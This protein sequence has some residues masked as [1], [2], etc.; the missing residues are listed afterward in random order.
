MKS[1][2]SLWATGDNQ[3][4]LLG[5]NQSEDQLVTTYSE[6]TKVTSV[7]TG[8]VSISGCEVTTTFAIGENG[9]ITDVYALGDNTDGALGDGNGKLLTAT[10][11]S[12]EMPFSSVPV[13][14]LLPE[15]ETYTMLASGQSY[16]L[17]ISSDGKMYGWGRNKG[18]QL[19]DGTEN[20][21]LQTSY[22]KKPI[23]IACPGGEVI[24]GDEDVDLVVVDASDIPTNL[25]DAKKIKLTGTWNTS[26]FGELAVAIGTSGF[27]ASNNTLVSVDMSEALIEAGTDLY[28]QGALSKNGVFVN[29]KALE[30]VV[31]PGVGEAANFSNFTNAFMNCEKL[32]DIDL[33]NC[34]G[35]T[36]LNSAF[37]N[38]TSLTDIDISS[39]TGLTGASSMQNAFDGCTALTKVVL[40]AEIAFSSS[41]FGDCTALT[42]ID[43]TSY[44]GT[45]AP[46]FYVDMFDGISDLKAITLTVDESVY[47]LFVADSNWSK[48][49]LKAY[50]STGINSV[51]VDGSVTFDGNIIFAAQPVS[52]VGVYAMSGSLVRS[53]DVLNGS[54]SIADIPA[55]IYVLVYT[56][57]GQKHALKIMK[58]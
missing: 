4:N 20:E 57:D 8:V 41:T 52:G 1:D 13:K 50:N 25:R 12:D 11:S 15:D 54:L 44:A 2:G 24:G 10:S 23:E 39:V 53:C 22:Q 17:V 5:F 3:D 37:M 36:S 40:P 45:E 43:W 14:V 6:F 30:T 16:S 21:Q 35:L 33:Q 55:G 26:A 42:D 34:T 48:L 31:M 46:I 19:G 27:G 58:K 18:G 28:V 32:V 7:P 51:E 47:D 29:C 49:T 38:C 9:K 56:Q